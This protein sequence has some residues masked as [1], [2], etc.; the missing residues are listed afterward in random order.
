MREEIAAENTSSEFKANLNTLRLNRLKDLIIY[1]VPFVICYITWLTLRT[2][3]EIGS[4]YFSNL[5]DIG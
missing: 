4:Y 2:N 3:S 1:R 5:C